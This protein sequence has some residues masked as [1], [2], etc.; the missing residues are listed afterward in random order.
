MTNSV[1]E[2]EIQ[3]FSKDSDRWWDERGPFAP[4]HRLNPVRLSYIK[5]QICA[6][7]GLDVNALIIVSNLREPL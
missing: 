2:H 3:Q 1:D 6:H 4:L 5:A 7:Y